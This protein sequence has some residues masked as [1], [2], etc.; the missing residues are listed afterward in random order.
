MARSSTVTLEEVSQLAKDLI[1]QGEKPTIG[2]VR[3]LLGNRGSPN[4]ISR[5]LK[6]WRDGEI[7]SIQG[8]QPKVEVKVEPL[9]EVKLPNPPALPKMDPPKVQIETKEPPLKIQVPPPVTPPPV[10]LAPSQASIPRQGGSQQAQ[11]GQAQP[12]QRGAQ[13]QKPPQAQRLAGHPHP[14]RPNHHHAPKQQQQQ[15]SQQSLKDRPFIAPEDDVADIYASENL[16]TL[17]RE[18]LVAKVRRLESILNKEQ[19]RREN[20]DSM[21][22][23]AKEYAES[24]K[25]QISARIS[26]VRHTMEVTID[27]LH[28]QLKFM[29]EMMEK[30][31]RYYREHL[32]K[33]EQKLAEQRIPS[34]PNFQT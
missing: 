32:Q 13:A 12:Q 15:H 33:A 19:F 23:D 30:D 11:N 7:A 14:S 20:A 6:E 27:Q 10:S 16:E 1:A 2:R 25:A 9:P 8:T 28:A 21:A 18:Q 29:R 24:L 4:V 34:R 26:D 17:S 5:F 31:L 22:R 3:E